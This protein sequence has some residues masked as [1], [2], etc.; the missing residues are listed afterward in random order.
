MLP[1]VQT[2]AATEVIARIETV[3]AARPGGVIA[4]DGDGTLW[5]GDVGDDFFRAVV[6]NG[7]IDAPATAAMR[8]LASA[9][10]VSAREDGPALAAALYDAYI[11]GRVPEELICEMVAYACAGWT[12]GEVEAFARDVLAKGGIADRMQA[13]TWTVAEWALRE[14]IPAFVVSASPRV[15]VAL[16]VRD[17]GFDTDHVLAATPVTRDGKLVAD[18]LRPIPYGPGKVTRLRERAGAAPLYAAFGDNVFDIPL[19]RA[20]EIPVAVRPKPRLTE[21][22]AEVPGLVVLSRME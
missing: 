16:A 7:R 17:L 5:S 2:V 12:T 3:R 6:A 13:E 21:R 22:V 14:R 10:G 8:A 15:I 9:H 18:V 11:A 4:L 19:L 1:A 20:A